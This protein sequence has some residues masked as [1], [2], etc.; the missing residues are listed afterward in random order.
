MNLEKVGSEVLFALKQECKVLGITL[1]WSKDCEPGNWG[2]CNFKYRNN[3]ATITI[4]A[5]LDS[6]LAAFTLAH[7]IG[8]FFQHLNRKNF[9]NMEEIEEDADQYF[10]K[11]IRRYV[12]KELYGE[13]NSYV[14]NLT[15]K[16]LIKDAVTT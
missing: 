10:F 7:E 9:A 2:K 11:A 15:G 6:F 14:Y 5:E 13:L 4:N 12:D 3:K 8:H 16:R 1:K